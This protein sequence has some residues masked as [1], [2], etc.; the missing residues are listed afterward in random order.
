MN[1]LDATGL[2][3]P[4]PV[5]RAAKAMRALAA[6]DQLEVLATDPGSVD[7]FLAYA[8]T[9]GHTLVEQSEKDGVFRFVLRRGDRV[10]SP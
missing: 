6:G 2:K 9:S 10:K 8:K 5:L 7:D 1:T 3:C 4:L